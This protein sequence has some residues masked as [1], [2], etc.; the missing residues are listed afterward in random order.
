[1]KTFAYIILF[2][3]FCINFSHQRA[4]KDDVIFRHFGNT[5]NGNNQNVKKDLLQYP[6]PSNQKSKF[7]QHSNLGLEDLGDDLIKELVGKIGDLFSGIDLG[8]DI[9]NDFHK[10]I[11]KLITDF[12]KESVG[13][14]DGGDENPPSDSSTAL[15]PKI[16]LKNKNSKLRGPLKL[17]LLDDG[18]KELIGKITDLLGGLGLGGDIVKDLTKKITDLITDFF[19][20]NNGGSST[21]AG[22][23]GDVTGVPPKTTKA[24]ATEGDKPPTPPVTQKPP[25][26]PA[27]PT[28]KKNAK[29]IFYCVF[30]L[31][32]LKS[33]TYTI[34]PATIL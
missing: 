16:F 18:V 19:K 20:Q 14:G 12:I 13:V 17:G 34:S 32:V 25:E 21:G 30:N 24:A 7:L 9:L 33:C 23:G 27:A 28:T 6:P 31:Y 22:G 1:M 8:S 15:P 5:K 10:T 3:V 2:L 11:T 4:I 26:T 29:I